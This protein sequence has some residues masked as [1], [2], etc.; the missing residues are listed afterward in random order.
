M[1]EKLHLCWETPRQLI[2]RHF[3]SSLGLSALLPRTE[4]LLAM[5]CPH[6]VI[7]V[8]LASQ[9]LLTRKRVR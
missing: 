7:K 9:N 1:S 8:T 2:Q 5:L 4:V 3:W 6:W